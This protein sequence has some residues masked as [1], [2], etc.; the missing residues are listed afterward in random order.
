MVLSGSL[1]GPSSGPL[2]T[3]VYATEQFVVPKSIAATLAEGTRKPDFFLGTRLATSQPLDVFRTS[4]ILAIVTVTE[5]QDVDVRLC[6]P[7]QIY[8]TWP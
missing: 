5:L 8:T 3:V 1:R 6:P 4:P 2:P 7:A